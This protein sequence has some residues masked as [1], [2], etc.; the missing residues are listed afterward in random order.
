MIWNG[1]SA[2]VIKNSKLLIVKS[3]SENKWSIPT[4]GIEAGESK[5]EALVREVH[6]ETGYKVNIIRHVKQMKK[7]VKEYDVTVDYFYCNIIG[8]QL[9]IIDPDNEIAQVKWIEKDEYNKLNWL[10]PED[11]E[12]IF[13]Y[14]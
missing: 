9:E 8:G 4:G 7:K 1:V 6:E 13:N 3:K 5:E 12:M 2:I 14:L 10:Y 11:K